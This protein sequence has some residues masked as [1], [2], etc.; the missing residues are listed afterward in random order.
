MVDRHMMQTGVPA[1]TDVS[2]VRMP[3]C[4]ALCIMPTVLQPFKKRSKNC[5]VPRSQGVSVAF[6]SGVQSIR[7]LL[8]SVLRAEWCRHRVAQL[9]A[10]S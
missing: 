6:M 10:R 8:R 2:G 1:N 4:G 5:S 9:R 3:I 7:T